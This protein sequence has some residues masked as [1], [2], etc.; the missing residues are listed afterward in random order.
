MQSFL[1]LCGATDHAIRSL[2]HSS[3]QHRN[4]ATYYTIERHRTA[5]LAQ[6]CSMH[7]LWDSVLPP[8][9][10]H[11]AAQRGPATDHIANV[12]QAVHCMA[13]PMTSS[14]QYSWWMLPPT[15][16]SYGK[17]RPI[18]A[19]SGAPPPQ[20]RPRSVCGMRPLK[21]RAAEPLIFL[22]TRAAC[23]ALVSNRCA[24][25]RPRDCGQDGCCGGAG[26]VPCQV[27]MKHSL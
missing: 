13:F 23:S 4:F 24:C 17:A 11:M 16:A 25:F 20:Q 19:P 21:D 22:C 15:A 27:F 9:N 7:P 14:Y 2:A 10:K 5:C 26:L 6:T 1:V 18:G 3:Y 8:D 12:H